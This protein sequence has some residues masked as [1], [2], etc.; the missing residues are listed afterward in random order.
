MKHFVWFDRSG[1]IGPAKA[2]VDKPYAEPAAGE[3]WYKKTPGVEW[4]CGKKE[5]GFRLQR[6]FWKN[7][8]LF[9]GFWVVVGWSHFLILYF[10]AQVKTISGRTSAIRIQASTMNAETN[11]LQVGKA[12]EFAVELKKALNAGN[13]YDTTL[14]PRDWLESL[15]GD[16]S[17]CIFFICGLWILKIPRSSMTLFINTV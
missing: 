15:S 8:F 12:F 4:Y 3:M 5:A 2:E 9:S 7:S 14:T 13:L 17:G 16:T 6:V 1:K 11:A 10:V